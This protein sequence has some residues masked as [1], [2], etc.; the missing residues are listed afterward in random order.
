MTRRRWSRDQAHGE[1]GNY[2][3]P[4]RIHHVD[5]DAVCASAE[6]NTFITGVKPNLIAAYSWCNGMQDLSG[7]D[8]QNIAAACHQALPRDQ[9]Q[10]GR[11]TGGREHP[12][13]L[14][15]FR[16]DLVNLSIGVH[17]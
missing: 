7:C 8:L 5:T 15:G 14:H 13:D 6:V 16:I 9:S 11:A 10:A 17:V 12:R 1:N 3:V 4:D 2:V